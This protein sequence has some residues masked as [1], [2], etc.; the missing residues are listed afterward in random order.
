MDGLWSLGLWI[1]LEAR[2]ES[3]VGLKQGTITDPMHVPQ[4]RAFGSPMSGQQYGPLFPGQLVLS[5][6]TAAA[7]IGEVPFGMGV[8]TPQ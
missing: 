5:S 4:Q 7:Y 2:L 1:E 3:S 8:L 6:R